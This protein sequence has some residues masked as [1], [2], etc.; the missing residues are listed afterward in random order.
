MF[1]IISKLLSFLISPILWI[2]GFIVWSI[3]VKNNTTRKKILV[4]I[5]VL[6]FLFTNRAFLNLFVSGFEIPPTQIQNQ[7]Y[8]SGIVLGGYSSFQENV[9]RLQFSETSD[10]L[11]QTIV[12]YKRGIIS[13]IILT[14]GSGSLLQ[15][16]KESL[17][18]KKYLIEIGIPEI[19]IISD[20]ESKNTIENAINTKR[21]LDSLDFKKPQLLIT[22]ASHMRRSMACFEKQNVYV[23]P[24]SVN[25]M[26]NTSTPNL[27]FYLVPQIWVLINWEKLIHEWAGYIAYKLTGKI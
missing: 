3:L 14:G 23:I 25:A 20:P 1:F 10:R 2:L 24:F 17:Y 16:N 19:D 8:E 18:A 12:L 27:E 26:T 15:T 4:S 21:I 7:K 6:I 11:F 9:N 13:K 5:F 22:S